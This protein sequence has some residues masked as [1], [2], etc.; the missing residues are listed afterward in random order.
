MAM[1]DTY[2]NAIGDHGASIINY[3]ALVNSSGTVVS[4]YKSV[5]WDTAVSGDIQVSADIDF[6]IDAG[7]EVAGWRGYDDDVGTTEYGGEDFGT[8][9]TFQNAGTFTLD[10]SQTSINH[11]AA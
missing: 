6:A 7:E 1:N 10:A 2:L 4:A 3:I 9:E 11:N 5:S 8:A